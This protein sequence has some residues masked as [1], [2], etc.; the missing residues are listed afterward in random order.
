MTAEQVE[1]FN[2]ESPPLRP[3]ATYLF[4]CVN[5]CVN[6]ALKKYRKFSNFYAK[7]P[8]THAFTQ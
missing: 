3:R 8:V 6:G 7:A 2:I 5:V 1:Y 4:C